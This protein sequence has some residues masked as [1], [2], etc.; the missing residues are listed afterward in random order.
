ML[1]RIYIK[2]AG[3]L[4]GKEATVIGFVQALRVQSKI[5]FLVLRDVSGLIQNVIEI[6]NPEAFEIAKNLSLESVVSITGTVKEA[7]QA[8]GGIE[9]DRKSVV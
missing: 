3:T 5:I 9:I 4:V 7:K 8:I 1:S 6:S 2:D